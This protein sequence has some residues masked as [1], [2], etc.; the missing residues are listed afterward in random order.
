MEDLKQPRTKLGDLYFSFV[1][2]GA[3][4]FG[5]GVA[6]LPMLER[7]CVDRHHWVTQ[8]RLA[9][10]FAIGQCTPGIIAVNV[11]TFIGSTER[12]MIGAAMTT[13]GV[14]TPSIVIILAIAAL[15]TN[16]ADIP[17]VQHA[18]GGIRVAVC[19]LMLNAVI[20]LVKSNVKNWLSIFICVA[21]FMLTAVFHLSPVFPV[22]GAALVGLG[23]GAWRKRA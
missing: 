8:E 12:G 22:I 15:L 2:I 20:K 19:V 10:Y 3:L 6:M 13:L 7:E 23:T 4:T 5:G 21:A 17:A 14:I 1:R 11:A 9:E 16:F 18:F